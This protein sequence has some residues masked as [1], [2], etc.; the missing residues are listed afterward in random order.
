MRFGAG[1][2]RNDFRIRK[3]FRSALELRRRCV[4]RATEFEFGAASPPKIA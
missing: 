4:A 1:A 3:A 2:S